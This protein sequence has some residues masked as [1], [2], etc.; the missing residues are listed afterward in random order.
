MNNKKYLI[1]VG[2]L[3]LVLIPIIILLFISAFSKRKTAPSSGLTPTPQISLIPSSSGQN[4]PPSYAPQS[5]TIISSNPQN[6]SREV[7]LTAPVL[8]TLS[9][10]IS[11]NNAQV[12]TNP[13]I[14]VSVTTQ[15]NTVTISPQSPLAPA[16][17][18]EFII[19]YNPSLPATIY[20]FR[21]AGAPP[22]DT[23]DFPHQRADVDDITKAPDVYLSRRMPYSTN[24]F[25]ATTQLSNDTGYFEFN[26]TVTSQN[27]VQGKQEFLDW[28]K[29]QGL[30][31]SQIQ[32]L[33]IH[34]TSPGGGP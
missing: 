11:N 21:T 10:P 22:G 4:T 33:T 8:V 17:V 6:F 15:N 12:T 16:T 5:S 23:F 26:I 31:D 2:I 18:Y 14:P 34:Y 20:A 28:I 30:T 19:R 29:S 9:Q 3:V 24:D 13:V 25:S 27:L 7:P 32:S 1:F